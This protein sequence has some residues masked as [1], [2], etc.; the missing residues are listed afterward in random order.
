MKEEEK[1]TEEGRREDDKL[2]T[3]AREEGREGGTSDR[4]SGT[5]SSMIEGKEIMRK[6]GLEGN[7]SCEICLDRVRTGE[8]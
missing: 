7:S 3:A 6:R 5:N 1:G 4:Q 8:T 2:Y